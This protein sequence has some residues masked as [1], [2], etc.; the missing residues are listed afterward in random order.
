MKKVVFIFFLFISFNIR[1]QQAENTSIQQCITGFLTWHKKNNL[2][3]R[4][5]P[6]AIVKEVSLRKKLKK[7]M[8]DKTGVEK[9]LVFLRSGGF[10]SE[11]YLN[12][13]RGYFYEIDETLKK[14]PPVKSGSIVKIDGLDLDFI[15]QSFEPETILDHIDNGKIEDASI[16]GN[17]AIVKF[18][19]SLTSDKMLFTLTKENGKWLIDYIGYYE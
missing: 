6:Y 13:L 17:K 11:M 9:Y 18:I 5:S 19:V 1:A 3:D 16:L 10:L 14:S 4:S 15:L 2:H 7:Q 8:I 12:N